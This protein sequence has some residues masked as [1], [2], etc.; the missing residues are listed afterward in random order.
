MKLSEQGKAFIKQWEGFSPVAYRNFAGEPWT[1][2]YG[3]VDG[4][5]EGDTMSREDAD[6][7]FEHEII[8]YEQAV[9]SLITWPMTQNQFDALVSF[10]YNLGEGS[11]RSST[12]RKR[13]NSGQHDK[14]ESEFLRWCHAGGKKVQGLL[15]RRKAEAAMFM[16]L[17]WGK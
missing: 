17:P 9:N 1:I 14:V 4:V 13:V 15:N 12:L 7:R 10:T 5:R 3:F 11:L 8:P 16:G 6:M 2:G